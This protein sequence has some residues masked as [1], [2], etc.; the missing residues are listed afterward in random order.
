MREEIGGVIYD[1]AAQLKFGSPEMRADFGTAKNPAPRAEW[2]LR[3]KHGR[4]ETTDAELADVADADKEARL[5]ALHLKTLVAEKHEIWDDEKKVFR[6]VEWRDMAVL[7]RSPAGRAEI[8]AKHFLRARKFW[9]C[10][11]CCNCWTIRFRTCRAS[12]C[13]ARRS[14]ACRWTS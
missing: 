1:D 5:I 7:L 3:I 12:R 9:I 4:N 13:C 2:L 6:A 14:S 11:A 8:F 10:W